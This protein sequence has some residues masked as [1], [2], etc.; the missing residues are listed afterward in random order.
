MK[1]LALAALIAMTEATKLRMQAKAHAKAKTAIK[2]RSQQDFDAEDLN[3][4]DLLDFEEWN[5]SIEEI[6]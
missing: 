2:H 1:F 6:Y 3:G 4:D 5:A